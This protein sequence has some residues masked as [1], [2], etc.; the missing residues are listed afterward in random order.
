M[1][2]KVGSWCIPLPVAVQMWCGTHV[3]RIEFQRS[4]TQSINTVVSLCFSDH[5]TMQILPCSDACTQAYSIIDALHDISL[6]N[7]HTAESHNIMCRHCCTYTSVYM[8]YIPAG[9]MLMVTM[10]SHQL[11]VQH[12]CSCLPSCCQHDAQRQHVRFRSS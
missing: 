6:T 12:A 7:L 5:A 1:T 9:T 2:S 10:L 8:R 3:Q 11:C 4:Y